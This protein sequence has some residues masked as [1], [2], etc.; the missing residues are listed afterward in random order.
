MATQAVAKH[1]RENVMLPIGDVRKGDTLVDGIKHWEIIGVELPFGNSRPGCIH[2]ADAAGNLRH[3]S[4][5]PHE[6]VHVLR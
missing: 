6:P 3:L 2:C 4:Y 5:G 1:L